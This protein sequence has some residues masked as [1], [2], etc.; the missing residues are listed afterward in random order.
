MK[1][2]SKRSAR[3]KSKEGLGVNFDWMRSMGPCA[4]RAGERRANGNWRRLKEGWPLCRGESE[5]KHTKRY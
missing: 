3:Y 1:G 2:S 5:P 4:R